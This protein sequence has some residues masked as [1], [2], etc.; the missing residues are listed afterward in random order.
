M[1]SQA[2]ERLLSK[3]RKEIV[4]KML[5]RLLLKPGSTLTVGLLVG[6]VLGGFVASNADLGN[7]YGT[8]GNFTFQ[9][10]VYDE[11]AAN[12]PIQGATV[13]CSVMRDYGNSALIRESKVT[14]DANG[15]WK[16]PVDTS[17][18]SWWIGASLPQNDLRKFSKVEA[19]GNPNSAGQTVSYQSLQG[20][21]NLLRSSSISNKDIELMHMTLG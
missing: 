7:L 15:F 8:S 12:K 19:P 11:G 4:S 9:G 17:A 14:T 6:L 10:Y 3:P 1:Q 5:G 21:P 2:T 18:N 16:C 13:A 20:L